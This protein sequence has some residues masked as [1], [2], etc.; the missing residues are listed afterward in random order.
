MEV[1]V[2]SIDKLQSKIRKLKNPSVL[3]I[4][5]DPQMIPP[6]LSEQGSVLDQWSCYCGKIL[7]SL[8]D[9]IPA[10][11]ASFGVFAL[12]GIDGTM[13]LE[14]LF[15]DA[16]KLGYYVI[17]DIPEALSATGAE[18]ASN[19]LLGEDSQWTFDALLVTS[20][21]GS[22]SLKPFADKLKER[23]KAMFVVARTANRS[24]A[25]LQDLLTGTRLMH[26]AVADTADRLGQGMVGKCGY[27]NIGVVAAASSASSIKA[28]R[29]KHS[30]LFMLLDGYDYPN[31][32]AKNCSL[33]FDTFGHGA[34]ACGS[35]GILGAW[36]QENADKD[37]YVAEAVEAAQRMKKNLTRYVTVL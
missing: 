35:R 3:D 24:A 12:Y 33:A 19:L 20:Y 14:K 31:A 23:N 15:R 6:A 1:I 37:N 22:D 32:N 11:R 8:K 28:L 18:R 21:I 17:L 7:E 13:A 27:S 30:R 2:M 5:V 26:T 29:D 10:V 36:A 25:E 4:T 34:V 9:E 16:A